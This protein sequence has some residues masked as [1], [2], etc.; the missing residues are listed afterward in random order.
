M[1]LTGE[2]IER[3]EKDAIADSVKPNPL[4][5]IYRAVA[6]A[7]AKKIHD[8]IESMVADGHYLKDILKALLEEVKE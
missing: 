2:E 3:A 1:I 7:Q 6:R 8:K 4:G 5:D